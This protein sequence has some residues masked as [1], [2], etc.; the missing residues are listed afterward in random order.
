MSLKYK[1]QLSNLVQRAHTTSLKHGFWD[2]CVEVVDNDGFFHLNLEQVD[3]VIPT[4]L[5]LIHSEVSEAM[6][7]HRLGPEAMVASYREDGK[8]E[9]FPSELADIVIR[10]MDLAGAMNIDLSVEIE[11]KMQH[12][13]TRPFKHGKAY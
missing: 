2:D 11:K 12:N 7:C 3:Q 8:P 6:E 4:K 5:C 13:E 9:G 1:D 10:V